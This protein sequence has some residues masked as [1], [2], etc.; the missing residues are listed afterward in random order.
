MEK[1]L[2]VLLIGMLVLPYVYADVP[3]V[4]VTN[5]Y[6]EKDSQPYNKTVDF[7]VNGYGYTQYPG[8]FAE[9]EPGTYTPES[10]FSFSATVNEYGGRVYETYYMNYRHIDYFELEGSS[11][12]GKFIIKN[13]S[14]D[15]IPGNCS[16]KQQGIFEK[17]GKYYEF[18]E[19]YSTCQMAAAVSESCDKFLVA[20]PEKGH[21]AYTSTRKNGTWYQL[22]PQY[23]SCEKELQN[24]CDKFLVEIPKAQ[25]DI[26]PNLNRPI[27]RVCKLRFNLNNAEWTVVNPSN[28][29]QQTNKTQQ[30]NANN[31]VTPPVIK[32]EVKKDFIGEILCFFTKL[33]GG[34]C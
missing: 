21:E 30:L 17:D 22:T 1:I 24:S 9:K 3:T 7:T 26:D 2:F 23:F 19:K 18:S 13:I 31:S 5:V 4:T 14:A 10:V 15:A 6:F 12:N 8:E 27:E 34:S 20:I 11:A 28:N 25:A 16:Q 32:P 33:F 29:T